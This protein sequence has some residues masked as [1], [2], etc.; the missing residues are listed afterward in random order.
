MTHF[1]G[2][3]REALAALAALNAG[4]QQVSAYYLSFGPR[5]SL[6]GNDEAHHL[7][8]TR[9]NNAGLDQ[10]GQSRGSRFDN[11]VGIAYDAEFYDEITGS[12]FGGPGV[13][14]AGKQWRAQSP[15]D[16][17]PCRIHSSPCLVS[18]NQPV[19]PAGRRRLLR[20]CGGRHIA[21]SSPSFQGQTKPGSLRNT[22]RR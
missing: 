14:Q 6:S 20:R 5:K 21:F 4:Q 2:G 12:L 13:L 22:V 7:A 17:L 8:N 16:E 15:T 11:G 9:D 1:D 10:F 18:T 3:G 19:L